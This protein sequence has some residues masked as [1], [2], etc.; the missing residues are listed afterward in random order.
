MVTDTAKDL[1]QQRELVLANILPEIFI[2]IQSNILTDSTT[3]VVAGILKVL[4]DHNIR[5]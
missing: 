1:T 2:V 3:E 4:E 5:R